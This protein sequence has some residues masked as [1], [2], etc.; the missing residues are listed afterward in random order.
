MADD[1][2]RQSENEVVEYAGLAIRETNPDEFIISERIVNER[3]GGLVLPPET[4][5]GPSFAFA[6]RC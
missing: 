5:L 1:V 6:R 2:P 4:A 3:R